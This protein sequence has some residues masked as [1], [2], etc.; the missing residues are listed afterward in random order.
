[1]EGG[2]EVL[3]PLIDPCATDGRG[4]EYFQVRVDLQRFLAGVLQV[5]RE[6]RDEVGFGDDQAVGCG[7]SFGI[8]FGLVVSFRSGEE[9]APDVFSQVV[10]GRADEVADILD[11]QD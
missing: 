5:K 9:H 2:D 11:E 10:A 6:H 4:Q 1:V 8:F 7:E 3:Y